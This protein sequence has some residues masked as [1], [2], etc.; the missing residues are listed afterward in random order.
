MTTGRINQVFFYFFSKFKF[1]D[2]PAVDK[3]FIQEIVKN[4]IRAPNPEISGHAC[5][6]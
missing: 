1:A 5:V 3:F 2:G 6:T 4:T